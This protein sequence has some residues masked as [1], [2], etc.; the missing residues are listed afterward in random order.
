MAD[1]APDDLKPEAVELALRLE[2]LSREAP[3]RS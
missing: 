1:R 3:S 2:S